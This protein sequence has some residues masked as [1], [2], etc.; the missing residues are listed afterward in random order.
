MALL[1]LPSS[2]PDMTNIMSINS[3][4]NLVTFADEES[5]AEYS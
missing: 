2:V 4:E 5:E 3:Y 1:Y